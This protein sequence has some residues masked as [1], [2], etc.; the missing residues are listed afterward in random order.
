[1]HGP[2][3]R[4]LVRAQAAHPAAPLLP[5]VGVG[6]CVARGRASWTSRGSILREDEGTSGRRPRRGR[7]TGI[8]R[9]ATQSKRRRRHRAGRE[10]AVC[11]SAR[12]G[13]HNPRGVC[14]RVSTYRSDAPVHGNVHGNACFRTPA[15]RV[16][17]KFRTQLIDQPL[18]DIPIETAFRPKIP[19]ASK[20]VDSSRKSRFLSDEAHVALHTRM[21]GAPPRVRASRRL[22]ARSMT[23][24]T[25][26]PRPR[27]S[28][29]ASARHSRRSARRTSTPSTRWYASWTR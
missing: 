6:G 23:W 3:G 9:P 17:I 13:H 11:D 16:K 14:F 21:R 24:T 15:P 27:P 2:L 4:L 5:G 8:L 7:R 29:S 19:W 25:I 28:P 18:S 1:M 26:A 22:A 12:R 20:S 10:C